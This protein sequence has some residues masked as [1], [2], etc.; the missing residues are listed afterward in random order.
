MQLSLRDED[1]QSNYTVRC[2]HATRE[3]NMRFTA[4]F[5]EFKGKEELL[6]FVE[7]LLRRPKGV[8]SNCA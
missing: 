1:E 6:F 7:Q 4:L 8:C 3:V 2:A 5:C